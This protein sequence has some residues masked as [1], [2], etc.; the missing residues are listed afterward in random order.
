MTKTYTDKEPKRGRTVYTRPETSRLAQKQ[1]K[2]RVWGRPTRP[3]RR[4]QGY[5]LRDSLEAGTE[6]LPAEW[7]QQVLGLNQ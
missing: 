2:G 3:Y 1:T 6:R 7:R 5:N 4:V